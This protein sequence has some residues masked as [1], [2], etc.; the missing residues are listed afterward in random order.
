MTEITPEKVA[1]MNATGSLTIGSIFGINLVTPLACAYLDKCE[2][3]V[4]VC[5]KATDELAVEREENQRL[6][7]II[8]S[9][10]TRQ[11]LEY[12]QS[13]DNT[14]FTPEE[15]EYLQDSIKR[16]DKDSVRLQAIIDQYKSST[17]ALMKDN[18]RLQTAYGEKCTEYE[19]LNTLKADACRSFLRSE[20][21]AEPVYQK[22]FKECDSQLR[23]TLRKTETLESEILMNAE[24]TEENQRL[25]TIIDKQR[26]ALEDFKKIFDC[27]KLSLTPAALSVYFLK[28]KEAL[29][30]TAKEGTSLNL[31]KDWCEKTFKDEEPGGV[32]ACN[33]DHLEEK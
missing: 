12:H 16:S 20:A 11:Y 31:S 13:K 1:L 19:K 6:Q 14:A 26:E 28:A 2:E 21:H 5:K 27:D 15:M 33:P 3:V 32:M 4:D 10:T 25:Q 17:L 18:E 8:A 29:A 22:L 23:K 7:S 30:L 24:L 9:Q